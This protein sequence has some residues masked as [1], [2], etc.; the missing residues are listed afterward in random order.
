MYFL[1]KQSSAIFEIAGVSEIGRNCLQISFTGLVF[2]SGTML[3]SLQD[4][5]IVVQHSCCSKQRILAV[6]GV[7]RSIIW[8]GGGG[9]YSYIRVLHY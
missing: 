3:A 6:S 5:V 7:G 1:T 8:G 4:L 2:I 9:Q